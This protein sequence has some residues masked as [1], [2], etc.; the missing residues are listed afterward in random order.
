[1]EELSAI[2]VDE[3]MEKSVRAAAIFSQLDQEHTDRIT[4]A[5]YEAGFNHRV[6]LA[7][8][9]Q[10]ETGSGNWKDKVIKNV[11]ATQFVY[12]DIKNLKTAG[13]IFEDEER[14]IVE[15][16]Q[17]IGPIFAIVPVTN[18]T[19]TVLFKILIALK[20]RNP[21]II[22]SSSKSSKVFQ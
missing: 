19:S 3:V 2:D 5:V 14:G 10:E 17:P 8:L 7:K 12:E 6:H 20:T 15:I 16:A 21:I 1:M 13:I 22:F 4:R 9:A 18:P 11:V